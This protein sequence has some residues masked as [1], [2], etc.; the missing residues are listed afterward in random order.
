[1]LTGPGDLVPE[2]TVLTLTEAARRAG[3]ATG[4]DTLSPT[5]I[6]RDG[7][8]FVPAADYNALLG[9]I[10]ARED[11]DLGLRLARNLPLDT[12]GLWGFLL[13]SSP[14][15]G[16]ML[17]RAGRYIRVFYRYTRMTLSPTD[18]GLVLTCDHPDPSPFGNRPQEV[19][20][21]LGQWLTWG[22]SV[23]AP[24]V[25]PVRVAM[26]WEGPRDPAPSEAFFACPVGFGAAAD[27]MVFSHDLAAT[28][29]PERAPELAALFEDYA[30]AFVRGLAP[31]S[32]FADEVRAVLA[33][34]VLQGSASEEQ[35]AAVLGVTPRT[36]RRRLSEEGESF[37]ALRTALLRSR[38]EDLL[39]RESV[40]IA[41]VSYLLGYS[42]PA[43]FH[44]AF[45]AWTG[46]SPAA[47]RD[48][49][50]G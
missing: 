29:L 4:A 43:T 40:P 6:E 15:F 9:R 25:A 30:A 42:E 24:E 41:E 21:F 46:H 22:R 31:P 11:E 18:E 2:R 1:M 49:Q 14:T 8:R 5:R 34:R 26:R 38:A 37:R 50:A 32:G 33:E 19:A 28:P 23:L 17:W 45:R 35:V 20:F 12:T 10:F 27:R 48:A 47:W 7:A 36:L 39:R 44:R 3:V 16:D 13:R